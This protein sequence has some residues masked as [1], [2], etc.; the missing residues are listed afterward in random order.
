MWHAGPDVVSQ[1]DLEKNASSRENDVLLQNLKPQEFCQRKLD[2]NK[3]SASPAE[4]VSG[5]SVCRQLC[6][7]TSSSRLFTEFL[8]ALKQSNREDMRG[9]REETGIQLQ[10]GASHLQ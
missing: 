7:A 3:M 8:T 9:F 5:G 4:N 2:A 10:L 6:T 1:R